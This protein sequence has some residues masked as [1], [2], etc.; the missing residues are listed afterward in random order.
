MHSD[1]KSYHERYMRVAL[2]LAR[3]QAGRTYP[4]PNV[5]AVIV[6]N[7]QI[8]AHG[9]TADG[10]RPHAETIAIKEAGKEVIGASLYV[11]LEPCSHH[12]KTPP[13]AEAI[14]KAGIKEVV[15]SCRDKNPQVS[16][17][18]VKMLKD[19]GI[20]VV[21]GICEAEGQ[22]IVRGFFSVIEKKRPFIALKIATSLDGKIT[23]PAGRWITGKAAR[24][25]GHLLRARY[26]AILTGS[27]TVIVDDPLLTCRLAGLEHHS[28]LRVI[29]DRGKRVPKS[30]KLLNDGK[31]SWVI[32][33]ELPEAIAEITERGITSILV[34]AG[35][36][37][38]TAFLASGMVDV[39]YWFRAPIIIGDGGLSAMEPLS[40]L[41]KFKEIEHIKLGSDSLDILECLPE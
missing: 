21:E 34:E 23:H 39:V 1:T 14:I 33:R 24:D 29:L 8:I 3:G 41:V 17:G 13:C 12:G 15:I 5:G 26:D 22:E 7:N 20:E 9:V 16:G 6:K 36:K 35:A 4:N 18:G 38:S 30:A 28:P 31:E 2:R 11:T 32:S 19:V 10:G 40:A 37:L 27:G 25:Y